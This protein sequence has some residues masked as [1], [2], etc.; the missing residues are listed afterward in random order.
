MHDSHQFSNFG[1]EKLAGGENRGRKEGTL[2]FYSDK[3]FSVMYV[4]VFI[5]PKG[6]EK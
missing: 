3:D 6:G 1:E 5:F 4:H 2:H